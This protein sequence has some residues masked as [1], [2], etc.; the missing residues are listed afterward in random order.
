LCRAA[1]GFRDA[2]GKIEAGDGEKTELE[3]LV[4]IA[5]RLCLR[6][7]DGHVSAPERMRSW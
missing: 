7:N 6:L 3:N 2:I 4:T 1:D 5:L